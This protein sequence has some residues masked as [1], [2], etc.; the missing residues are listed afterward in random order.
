MTVG[1][2]LFEDDP[3][4]APFWHPVAL[5]AAVDTTPVAVELLGG[6]WALARLD[7]NVVALPDRCPHRLAPLSAGRIVSGP[8][9]AELQCGYHG[10]RFE[11]S[12]RCTAVPA[13][14]PG[15]T[16]PPRAHLLPAEVAE[17]YG[18]VWLAPAAPRTGLVEIPDA[19]RFPVGLLDVL[20]AR[21]CAGS[22][23]DNFCD[24]AHFP[25]VHAGTFGGGAPAEVG[26]LTVGSDGDWTIRLVDEHTFD[27][28]EDPA[29][30]AGERALQQRRRTTYVVHAPFTATLRLENLDQG[31]TSTILFAV[32]PAARHRCR[33]FTALVRDDPPEAMAA[34]VAYEAAVLAEDLAVQERLPAGFPIELTTE[35]H[36]R[37]DR[38]TVELRRMLRRVVEAAQLATV[39]AP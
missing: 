37:A 9:G 21:A 20:E 38:L 35:V 31:V 11:R 14:G 8:C 10:W 28:H 25:F 33:I 16:V 39:G 15:A 24:L 34:A 2:L 3:A 12:G 27:N 19:E 17:R 23:L 36:T 32:Q 4:L 6:R 18:I 5:S 29:V 30:A 7:G 13:L 22:L 1:A 26:E